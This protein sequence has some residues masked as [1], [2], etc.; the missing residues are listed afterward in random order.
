MPEIDLYNW[1][2]LE[3]VRDT[4]FRAKDS[5]GAVSFPIFNSPIY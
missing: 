3:F 4:Q 5:T 1:F 2:E